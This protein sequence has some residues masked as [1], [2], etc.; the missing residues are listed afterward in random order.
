MLHVIR[1]YNCCCGFGPI[2]DRNEPVAHGH[3]LVLGAG[4]S[5]SAGLFEVMPFEGFATY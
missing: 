2:Y 5:I 4:N 1:H 3:F